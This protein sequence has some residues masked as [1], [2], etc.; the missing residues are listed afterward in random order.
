MIL[1]LSRDDLGRIQSGYCMEREPRQRFGKT[2][3]KTCADNT[4]RTRTMVCGEVCGA[5]G[6]STAKMIEETALFLDLG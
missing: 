2:S 3:I 1:F 4:T 6:I 5:A